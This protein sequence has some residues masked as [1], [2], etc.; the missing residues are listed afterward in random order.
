M[1]FMTRKRFEEEVQK[2]IWEEKDREELHRRV[3]GAYDRIYDLER[4]VRKLESL[5]LLNGPVKEE[6]CDDKFFMTPP[7]GEGNPM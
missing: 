2:R 1:L 3:E 6:T 5:L 7:V 4:K